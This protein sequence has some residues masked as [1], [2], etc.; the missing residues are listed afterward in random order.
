LSASHEIRQP[1]VTFWGT[2]GTTPCPEADFARYGGHTSCVQVQMGGRNIILD[3]GTGLQALD[4]TLDPAGS[5]DLLFSHSHLDHIMGFP[6]FK[7]LFSPAFSC[8]VRAGHL[9]DGQTIKQVVANF[10][11]PPYFPMPVTSFNAQLVYTDFSSGETFPLGQYVTVQTIAINHT[12]G[13]T[14]YRLHD[15]DKS[16]C[17]LTDIEHEGDAYP[18]GWPDP[19][20]ADFVRGADILIYDCS[21]TDEEY[22]E[23]RGRGHSSWQAGMQLAEAGEVGTFVIFHHDPAH[24]DDFMDDIAAQ[25]AATRPGTV[26]ARDGM[27]L[28]L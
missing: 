8:H 27:V 7:T 1:S 15:G 9:A 22:A 24:N 21:Y 14:G 23:R 3:A 16:V 11:Q 18:Q 17:Y 2:R 4:K 12:N 6:H 26:V 5:V 10:M 28:A 19:A 20:L 13:A 25:A